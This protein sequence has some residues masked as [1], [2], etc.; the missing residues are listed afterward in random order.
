LQFLP[1]CLRLV[2][3]PV[4]LVGGGTV[5]TR[6]ARLLLRAGASLTVVSPTIG[7]ELQLM[8]KEHLGVWRQAR[9]TE[10]ELH[11]KTLVVAATADKLTNKQIYQDAIAA[12]ILVNVV[13][14]PE[15]QSAVVVAVPC[16]QE[17][18]GVK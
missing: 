11:G 14:S 1:I 12:S 18:F 15:L 9:Y 8:L 13:D 6:K 3:A 5:A 10:V 16:S 7:D 2:D 4:V 17:F